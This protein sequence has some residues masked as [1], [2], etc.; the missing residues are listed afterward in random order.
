[1]KIND[2]LPS[3]GGPLELNYTPEILIANRPPTKLDIPSALWWY[4]RREKVM[5]RAT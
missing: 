2:L 3:W 5:Y 1:M 4:D